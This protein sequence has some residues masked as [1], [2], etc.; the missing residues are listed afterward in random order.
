MA[1]LNLD[2]PNKRARMKLKI[3]GTAGGINK[4]TL[5]I[6][7]IIDKLIR[8]KMS[9]D[10]GDAHASQYWP[11]RPVRNSAFRAREAENP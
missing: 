8:W 4:S 10:M 5:I 3:D 2:A 9:E 11:N 6:I 1:I 7:S